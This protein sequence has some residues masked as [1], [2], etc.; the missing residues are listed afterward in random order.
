MDMI[1]KVSKIEMTPM[2]YRVTA[3]DMD[4]SKTKHRNVSSI[5]TNP[6]MYS[7]GMTVRVVLEPATGEMV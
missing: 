7:V 5:I 2:G 3:R 4:E 6:E 1:Y